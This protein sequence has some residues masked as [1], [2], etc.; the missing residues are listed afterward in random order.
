MIHCVPP[1]GVEAHAYTLT[2][3]I[4]REL[5]PFIKSGRAV[6]GVAL[7]GYQERDWP[8]N[9]NQPS[10]TQVEY[11]DQ[12]VE[13]ITDLRHGLDYLETRPDIDTSRITYMTM[14]PGGFK[15]MLPAIESRYRSIIMTGAS[16]ES[17][18]PQRIPEANPINFVSRIRA[19]KLIMHGRYD[20]VDSLRSEAEPLFKLFGEPKQLILFEGGHIPDR[21][22][23]VPV[24]LQYLDKT[25]G[26]VK[27]L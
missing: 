6:L 12:I 8:A 18:A 17:D 3:F 1:G 25:L 24:F 10:P 2:Q 11:R 20:E 16:I 22:I 26:P 5:R 14:S 27:S 13:K 19:P 21:E 4:E 7:K 23:F 9:Y 15:L